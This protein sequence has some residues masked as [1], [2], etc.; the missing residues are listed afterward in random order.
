MGEAAALEDCFFDEGGGGGGFLR[1]HAVFAEDFIPGNR[2]YE[3]LNLMKTITILCLRLDRLWEH[4]CARPLGLPYLVKLLQ[5]ES[6]KV[7][8]RNAY[9][10]TGQT[11]RPVTWKT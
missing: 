4:L 7:A 9:A 1:D 11:D 2:E 5:V 8:L 10:Q 3:I 6:S